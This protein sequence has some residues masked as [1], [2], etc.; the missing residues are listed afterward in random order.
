MSH[1]NSPEL[2]SVEQF[3]KDRFGQYLVVA[4]DG[5]D[6]HVV[7]S[8][9]NAGIGLAEYAKRLAMDALFEKDS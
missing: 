2:D 3:L 8:S 9:S 1:P 5:E 7:M 4:S 6:V